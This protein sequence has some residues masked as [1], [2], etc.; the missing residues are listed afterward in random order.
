MT[1]TKTTAILGGLVAAVVTSGCEDPVESPPQL[2]VTAVTPARGPLAGATSVTITGTN[3]IDVTSAIIGGNELG[4]RVVVSA[5][6]MTGTTPVANSLGPSDVVVTSSS[7]GSGRC[8]GCFKYELGIIAQPL[9]AGWMST[10]AL[11]STGA[12]YCWGEASGVAHPVA[13]SGDLS[14]SALSTANRH[15]CGL[16]GAGAASCWGSNVDGQLGD[17]STM[18]SATPVAV[19]GGLRLSAIAAGGGP[20]SPPTPGATQDPRGHTCGL[21][22]DGAAYCWG[23]NFVG[24][25]GSGSTTSSS[26]PV[27]VSTGLRFIA[28]AAAGDMLSG[29]ILGVRRGGHTCGLTSTGAAYCW[30]SNG[31]NQLGDGSSTDSSVPVA[32]AGGLRF[33]ALVTGN[34]HTCGL[35]SAG[36]AYCWGGSWAGQLGGSTPVSGTTVVPVSGGLTFSALTAGNAHTCGLIASGAA[37]C[38]GNNPDGRLGDGSTTSSATPVTVSG[39]L[40]FTNLAAGGLHTCGRGGAGALYCWGNNE[41]GQ[42]GDGTT[43]NSSVPVRIAGLP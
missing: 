17:G 21:T 42:L 20:W 29:G 14:F 18:G 28:L 7:H 26:M 43:T 31:W 15:T 30:G 10:C 39:G 24:Q 19:V 8:S 22:S 11:T 25:L 13:V 37:Y 41:A 4:E 36:A 2:T 5:T 12:A 23:A 1:P 3:L 16:T 34:F 32:V 38:W 35:T 40:T 33:T 9:A 27:A 6:E